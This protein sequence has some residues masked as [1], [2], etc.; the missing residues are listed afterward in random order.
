LRT[1]A[2]K[3]IAHNCFANRDYRGLSPTARHGFGLRWFA[4]SDLGNANHTIR[5][6][7]TDMR[8]TDH[9]QHVMLTNNVY[10]PPIVP[11]VCDPI[12]AEKCSLFKS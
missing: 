9:R 8:V 5:R 4:A 12:T 3:R 1:D 6:Q 7:V 10:P 2:F 11:Q